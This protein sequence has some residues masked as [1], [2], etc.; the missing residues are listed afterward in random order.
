MTDEVMAGV[1]SQLSLM[2]T[3]RIAHRDLRLANVF[4][5]DDGDG[6]DHRLRLQ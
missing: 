4:L 2:R 3:H 1:W 6:L 5:A